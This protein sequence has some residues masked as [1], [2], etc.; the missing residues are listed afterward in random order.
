LVGGR[1]VLKL[2]GCR[3]TAV[4]V[5]PLVVGFEV[6]V[7]VKAQVGDELVVDASSWLGRLCRQEVLVDV[8]VES[9]Q[10]EMEVGS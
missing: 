8:V 7:R 2:G 9:A 4:R 1:K 5:D 10:A 6:T 3:L